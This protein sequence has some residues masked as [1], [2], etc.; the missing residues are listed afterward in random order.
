MWYEN[1]G[2]AKSQML[3][4]VVTMSKTIVDTLK[5]QV[6][7]IVEIAFEFLDCSVFLYQHVIH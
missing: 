4:V 1:L 3:Q 2:C 6:L 7:W 5:G